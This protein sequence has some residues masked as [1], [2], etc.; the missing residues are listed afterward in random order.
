MGNFVEK[1][2]GLLLQQHTAETGQAFLPDAVSCIWHLSQ[3]QPWLVNALAYETTF[4]MKQGQDRTR[5]I[6]K[7][8]VDQAVKSPLAQASSFSMT[9]S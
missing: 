8:M 4:K 1:E 9:A 3:G 7:E 6:D 5:P 2:V